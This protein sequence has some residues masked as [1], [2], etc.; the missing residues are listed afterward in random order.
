MNDSDRKQQANAL[1]RELSQ[2]GLSRR[3]FLDRLA[4]LG[5]SFG[6]ASV[7]GL[8]NADAHNVMD[9]SVSVQSTDPALSKIIE[10]GQPDQEAY[11]DVA[12]Y[13][14]TPGQPGTGWGGG[15]SGGGYTGNDYGRGGGYSRGYSRAAY[16][17]YARYTRYDRAYTRYDRTYARY[18]RSYSRYGG[19]GGG[20][21]GG[22]SGGWG[23]GGGGGYGGSGTR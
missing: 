1:Q 5:V 14:G 18:A 19:G 9:Q 15:S 7:L 6:A 8:R 16:E 3:A 12:Q 20:G 23:G 17:R 10:E 11:Q 21:Y 4:V 2:T 13:G 22:G